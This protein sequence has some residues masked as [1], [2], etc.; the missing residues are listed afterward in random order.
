MRR[1]SSDGSQEELMTNAVLNAD[2]RTTTPIGE[3]HSVVQ[4]PLPIPSIDPVV[5][6]GSARASMLI[7]SNVY[8]GDTSIGRIEDVLV[9]LEHATSTG[10]VVTLGGF[11][12]MGDKLVVVPVDQIKVGSEARFV[13]D[14]TEAQF[15]SAPAFDF[16]RN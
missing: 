3:A 13:T 12:G 6:A 10:V 2:T 15:A 1:G 11:L 16:G 4:P 9:D 7:G 5:L 14:L 8:R